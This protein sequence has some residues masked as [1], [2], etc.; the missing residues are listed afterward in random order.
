MI[1][2]PLPPA[3]NPTECSDPAMKA[4]QPSPPRLKSA[5]WAR[6]L[7]SFPQVDPLVLTSTHGYVFLPNICPCGNNG[8][9]KPPLPA[10][11]FVLLRVV[12][13]GSGTPIFPGGR[14]SRGGGHF[15]P[16]S[17]HAAVRTVPTIVRGGYVVGLEAGACSSCG[18]DAFLLVRGRAILSPACCVALSTTDSSS[19]DNGY[20][21][22][23]PFNGFAKTLV[24]A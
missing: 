20:C 13:P 1:T 19:G 23:P 6:E 24:P 2:W 21:E 17:L 15:S 11:G 12:R 18:A 16:P 7:N 14:H 9:I 3:M 22:T 8:R 10:G 5:F 4:E